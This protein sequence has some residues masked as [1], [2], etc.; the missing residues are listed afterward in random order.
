MLTLTL[1]S[2]KTLFTHRC[3]VLSVLRL[4]GQVLL[5]YTW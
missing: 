4:R 1:L 5:L 2:T 3:I